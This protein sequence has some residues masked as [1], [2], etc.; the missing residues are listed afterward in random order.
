M[1][2]AQDIKRMSVAKLTSNQPSNIRQVT[3]PVTGL[4]AGTG[5][6]AV[7]T[8]GAALTWGAWQD[9]ALPAAITVESLAVMVFID[10]PS[11][12]ESYTIQIGSTFVNGVA[13][14]NAA[15]V[16]AAGAAVI[17][18]AARANVRAEVISIVGA[19]PPI[20]LM[21]PVW[22]GAGHGIIARISDIS[23]ADTLN[24]TVAV[25]QNY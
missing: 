21:F 24:V 4:G 14:A 25:V 6:G 1:S 9:V 17:L 19:Y 8:A 18:A 20:P 10:T 5:L 11:I 15:A 12:L 16:T 13:Y 7:C 22:Y 2:F 23:G 3:F